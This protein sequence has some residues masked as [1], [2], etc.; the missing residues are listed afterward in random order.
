MYRQNFKISSHLWPRR[1]LVLCVCCLLGTL[2]FS[3]NPATR[4]NLIQLDEPLRIDAQA[5]VYDA[6]LHRLVIK[7]DSFH[8]NLGVTLETPAG[9]LQHTAIQFAGLTTLYVE[10]VS[11]AALQ[12]GLTITLSHPVLASSASVNLTAVPTVFSIPARRTDMGRQSVVR[13]T[14]QANQLSI[15]EVQQIMGQ[16]VAQAEADGLRAAVAVVDAEGNNLGVFLMTGAPETAR[17][18]LL[19]AGCTPPDGTVSFPLPCGLEG[20]R[21]PLCTAAISKAVT[22]SFLSSNGHAFTP[23]TASFIV[24]EHF[25]PGINFQA[26]GPLFGVQFS[27]LLCSDVN[28]KTPLGLSAG[29]GAIPLYKNGVKVGAIGIEGDGRYAFDPLPSDLDI[30]LEE[31]AALAG[32]RGFDPP[33]AITGDKIIVNGIRFPYVDASAPPPLQVRAFSQ[34]PGAI[35]SCCLRSDV[36]ASCIAPSAVRATLPSEFTPATI[37]DAPP[38][39]INTRLFPTGIA[40]FGSTADLSRDEVVR[41]IGQAAKQA[42]IT[43]AAIRQPL[44]SAAEVNISV[45][46]SNGKLLGLFSTTDAPQFGLDVAVQKARTAAFFSNAAAATLLRQTGFGKFVD[47]AARDGLRLDGSV[48][49]SDR[50]IGFLSRPLYPDGID[51]TLPG[52]FSLPLTYFSPFNVGFQLDAIREGYFENILKFVRDKDIPALLDATTTP[53]GNPLL[54]AAINNGF[55]IF[56]G[57]VP[58]YKN[59][60]LVGAIGISGDGV[61][62]DDLI[63]AMGSTGF[64]APADIRA[65]RISVRGTRLPYVKFPRQPNRD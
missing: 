17:V 36:A 52:P 43:R 40:S 24:Q 29:A 2:S 47:A 32:T 14:A 64:E 5:C 63:A 65:D 41:I 62:Q 10:G 50:A 19:R 7:G 20:V 1:W 28:P 56:P 55:Q 38:G 13:E 18:G 11:E 34:L 22:A 39:R 45:C 4:A 42:F 6:T 59:G 54:S 21:V 25:P 37:G 49:F 16:A 57:S 33:A 31:L 12:H 60:K 15:T 27:Q 51:R 53:C 46:D 30:A 44:N 26:S 48:A 3:F 23:R 35:T 9:S 8:P 61:D 58:L